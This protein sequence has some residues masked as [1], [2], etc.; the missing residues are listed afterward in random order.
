MKEIIAKLGSSKEKKIKVNK[1][2]KSLAKKL[3]GQRQP[4]SGSLDHRKGD[5]SLDKFLLDSKESTNNSLLISARDFVKI[6]READGERKK[7]GLVI[8]VE[9]VPSTVEKEWVMVP[10][11]VFAEMLGLNMDKSL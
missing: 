1:H 10:L 11:I 6:T 7:P 9:G 8:T 4:N 2:E 5:I 3:K